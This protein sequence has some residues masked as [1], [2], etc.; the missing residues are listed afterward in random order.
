MNKSILAPVIV[1][2]LLMAIGASAKS[3]IDVSVIN[4]KMIT[5]KELLFEVRSDIKDIKSILKER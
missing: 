4:S 1:G 2:I 5:F 3:I